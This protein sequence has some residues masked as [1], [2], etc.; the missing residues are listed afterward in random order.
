MGLGKLGFGSIAQGFAF[1]CGPLLARLKN[2]DADCSKGY[3]A[4]TSSDNYSLLGT[5]HLDGAD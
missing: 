1:L 2:D 3:Q 5:S 4:E